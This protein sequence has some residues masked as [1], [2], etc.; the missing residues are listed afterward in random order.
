[1]GKWGLW[2]GVHV[3]WNILQPNSGTGEGHPWALGQEVGARIFAFVFSLWKI[4]LPV[5]LHDSFDSYTV[6]PFSPRSHNFVTLQ[7]FKLIFFEAW[8][9]L[10]HEDCWVGGRILRKFSENMVVIFRELIQ[11][12][13]VVF[14]FIIIFKHFAEQSEQKLGALSCSDRGQGRIGRPLSA[15]ASAGLDFTLWR[16]SCLSYF[17]LFE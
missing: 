10:E 1:M 11:T 8:H 3:F 14:W 7:S 4:G 13:L 2:I 9:L 6:P 17:V 16:W 12:V 15:P 5:R